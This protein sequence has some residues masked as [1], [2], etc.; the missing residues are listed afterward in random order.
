LAHHELNSEFFR[1][2][3]TGIFPTADKKATQPELITPFRA[4]V[5]TSYG[6]T[7]MADKKGRGGKTEKLAKFE[8]QSSKSILMTAGV[9]VSFVSKVQLEK[10]RKLQKELEKQRKKT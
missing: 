6:A 9:P 4:M 10:R 5:Q 3:P 1:L 8:K 2:S 7:K